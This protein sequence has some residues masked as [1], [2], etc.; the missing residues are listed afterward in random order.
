MGLR[1]SF[2]NRSW[3]ERRSISSRRRNNSLKKRRK[4]LLRMI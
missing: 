3:I 1:L 4:R 2:R